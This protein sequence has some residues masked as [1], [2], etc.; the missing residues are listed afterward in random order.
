MHSTT[1][2]PHRKTSTAI[3][4][5]VHHIVFARVLI[6]LRRPFLI[7]LILNFLMIL[8]SYKLNFL[9]SKHNTEIQKGS[10]ESLTSKDGVVH[11]HVML[12]VLF[13]S[14]NSKNGSKTGSKNGSKSGS[15]MSARNLKKWEQEFNAS[16]KNPTGAMD[17]KQLQALAAARS[18]SKSA[19][20][21]S[22]RAGRSRLSKASKPPQSV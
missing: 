3:V 16:N 12:P 5:P 10:G 20:V 15:S 7:V 13:E 18:T 22:S 17:L 1:T 19:S 14:S 11:D 21:A 6:S 2:R 8:R 9:I 4:A